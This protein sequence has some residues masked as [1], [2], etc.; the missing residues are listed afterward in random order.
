MT[1][2][3]QVILLFIHE[4]LGPTVI[5]SKA[6]D[7]ADMIQQPG[8]SKYHQTTWEK[9]LDYKVSSDAPLLN[10]TLTIAAMDGARHTSLAQDR[11][12]RERAASRL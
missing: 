11:G 3:K 2:P 4:K 7:R 10:R 12:S 8:F 9:F 6:T 1:D 5:V